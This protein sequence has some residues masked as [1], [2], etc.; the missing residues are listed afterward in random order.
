M[1]FIPNFDF[2]TFEKIIS[3]TDLCEV[4]YSYTYDP[5]NSFISKDRNEI[6]KHVLIHSTP[7]SGTRYVYSSRNDR[8][9]FGIPKIIFGES[10]I[11][12]VI[13]DVNGDYGMTQGAIGIKIN[14]IEEGNSIKNA[15]LSDKFSK[16]TESVM[17]SNFRVDWRIFTN[18]KKDFWKEFI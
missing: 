18:L 12:D 14:S 3:N 2:D 11:N 5:R 9:H 13:I 10:G 1:P 16:F 15:L 8:G 4:I 7:K 6:F 17:W